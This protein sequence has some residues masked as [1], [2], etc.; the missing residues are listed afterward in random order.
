[1]SKHI[2]YVLQKIMLSLIELLRK[3][4]AIGDLEL[5]QRELSESQKAAFDNELDLIANN[6]YYLQ[7]QEEVRSKCC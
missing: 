1:M 5:H 3:D 2:I 7:N 6:A 4:E